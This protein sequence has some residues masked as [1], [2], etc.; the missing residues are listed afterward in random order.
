MSA[1]AWK[2]S[3]DLLGEDT[4]HVAVGDVIRT[5]ENRHPHYQIIAMSENR[6]WIRDIQ[7][8]TDH[9]VPIDRCRQ[10]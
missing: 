9:I 7:N 4:A 1:H 8:R 2:S 5:G 10:I 3:V 6:A